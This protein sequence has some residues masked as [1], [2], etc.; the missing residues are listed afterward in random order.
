MSRQWKIKV[1]AALMV[2]SMISALVISGCPG[3]AR[4]PAPAP[5]AGLDDLQSMLR[6]SASRATISGIVADSILDRAVLDRLKIAVISLMDD[7]DV[8]RSM[9]R[10]ITAAPELKAA[11]REVV[12]RPATPRVPSVSEIVQSP[13]LRS[14]IREIVI[15]E[16]ARTRPEQPKQG[17]EGME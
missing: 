7:A 14:V 15:Q 5:R 2:M 17:K 9:A 3:T 11:V 16:L 13:Q 1:A 6:T 12:G 4:R 10:A 8:R